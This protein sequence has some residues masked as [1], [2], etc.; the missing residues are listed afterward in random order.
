[1]LYQAE[2]AGLDAQETAGVHFATESEPE[3]VVRAFAERL[4]GWILAHRDEVDALI[5]E[6]S[7]NWSL[8]RLAA[9]DRNLLRLGIGELRAE[10]D[11][12]AAVIIDEAV[13]LARDYAGAESGAFVN[14]ILEAARRHLRPGAEPSGGGRSE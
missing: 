9:I 12:P 1:M 3:P 8:D 14:G 11:T 6:L 4:V 2:L 10:P 5:S 7:H 13:E